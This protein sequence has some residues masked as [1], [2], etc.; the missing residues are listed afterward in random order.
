MAG[1]SAVVVRATLLNVAQLTCR[2]CWAQHDQRAL[3]AVA[4][5]L[6]GRPRQTLGWMKPSEAFDQLVAFTA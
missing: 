3:D 5:E 6:N 4:D 1:T 2:L